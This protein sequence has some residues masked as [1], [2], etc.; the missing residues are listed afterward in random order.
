MS[1]KYEGYKELSI[2]L[3]KKYGVQTWSRVRIESN[4]GTSEGIILPRNKFAPDNYFEVKLKNGYNIGIPLDSITNVTLLEQTPRME[5]K[6]KPIPP[7]PKKNLPNIK[8]LG[9]GGTIAARL[10]YITGGVTPAFEPA[11]L[12]AAVPELSEICNID[13]EVMFK[14]FSEDM[15]PSKWLEMAQS[16]AKTANS[17]VDGIMILH[18]TDTMSFTSAALS[19]LLKD[20][21]VPV[22]IVGSQRSS[23]RPS[24]DA[25]LNLLNGATVASKADLAEV[26]VCMLGSSNH[27]YGL[28]HRGTRLRKMHSSMRHTFRTIGD[29]PLGAVQEGNI[30]YFKQD[31]HHRPTPRTQ[32]ISAKKIESKIG[33]IYAYPSMSSELIDFYIDKGYK[34][35]VFAG[36][37]LGHIPHRTFKSVERAKEANIHMIMTLQTIWGYTGMDV[38]ET[39]REEQALGIIP[40]QNML[41]E[42]AVAKL[43]WL[44]GN[45][46]DPNEIRHLIKTNVAGEITDGE[47][48]NGFEVYQGIEH[49]IQIDKKKN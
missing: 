43:A 3:M 47:P 25:A 30:R 23:D 21:S 36:T 4:T 32:T 35:I 17:G 46:D 15:E 37:G 16:V 2:A 1:E 13:S 48:I 42:V 40:G 8:I 31:I 38:Y 34:G 11:E 28:I 20:L 9:T 7:Q 39:G 5:V 33:L 49:L 45:Y 6:F 22:V 12:N 14:I 19:F 41:P 10:D 18:G 27:T 44:L 24:S 29:I 26:V